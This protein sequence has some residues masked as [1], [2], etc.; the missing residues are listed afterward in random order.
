[1]GSTS[2]GSG[3]GWGRSSRCS[4]SGSTSASERTPM[5][6]LTPGLSSA[7]VSICSASRSAPSSTNGRRRRSSASSST[8]SLSSWVRRLA[9]TPPKRSRSR[10][11]WR[12]SSSRGFTGGSRKRRS[13][14]RKCGSRSPPPGRARRS[15]RTCPAKR[16]SGLRHARREA[17]K[18]IEGQKAAWVS[19]GI[20]QDVSFTAEQLAAAAEVPL[21]AAE[22]FLDSFSVRFGSGPTPISGSAIPRR[23]SAASCRRC[24]EY[25]S[26]TTEPAAIC[27]SL[28]TR[29]S[30]G[31]ATSSPTPL[32]RTAGGRAR[33]PPC[34]GAGGQGGGA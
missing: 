11:P 22:A 24:A 33:P 7:R 34:P 23:R 32:S 27:R 28:S 26:S 17:E 8:P 4:G 25:R 30:T 1:M 15:P 12:R 2:R 3:S 31:F 29:S 21:S 14:P 9:S 16:S 19:L 20:G 6:P 10:R 5:I 18:R 13:S